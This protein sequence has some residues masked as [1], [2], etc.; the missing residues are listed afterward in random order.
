MFGQQYTSGDTVRNEML[1]DPMI[2]AWKNRAGK[3]SNIADDY[4]DVNSDF[5]DRTEE[6]FR[7]NASQLGA[8]QMATSNRMGRQNM[9]SMGIDPRSGI[10]LAQRNQQ[11]NKIQAD[12]ARQLQNNLFNTWQRGQQLA[13]TYDTRSDS[14]MNQ[15]GGL[16]TNA[17]QAGLQQDLSN[18]QAQNA[19]RAAMWKGGLGLLGN[20]VMPGLGGLAMNAFQGG[21][22]DVGDPLSWQQAWARGYQYPGSNK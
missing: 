17:Y 15:Y 20:L 6:F 19:N 21:M 3:Y 18:Q 7:R 9:A 16:T 11:I 10:G 14:A 12:Q 1:K 5:Y 4:R 22:N 8:D 2:Q 13:G